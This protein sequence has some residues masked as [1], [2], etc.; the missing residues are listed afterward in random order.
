MSAA[1]LKHTDKRKF[2]IVEN[3]LLML[4]KTSAEGNAKEDE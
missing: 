3:F 1:S 2:S 4:Y